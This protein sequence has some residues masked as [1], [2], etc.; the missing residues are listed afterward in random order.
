M[1]KRIHNL[2][3]AIEPGYLETLL[4]S[5]SLPGG[6]VGAEING[7]VEIITIRGAIS[8]R[9]KG[10]LSWLFGETATYESIREHFR[11]ALQDENTAAVIF[12]IDSSGGEVAGLFDLVDEIY[13]ARG[14]KPIYAIANENALSAAYAIASA[15]DKVFLTRTAQV[16]SIGVVAVHVDQSEADKKAGVKFTPIYAGDR[17]VD[18]S[19]HAPL[20]KEAMAIAQDRVNKSY[21][22][23]VS[24]VARNRGI[25]P[26]S[27][28][29]TQAGIFTGED[30]VKAGLAD[31][32]LSFN[33]VV[34][35]ILTGGENMGLKTDLRGLLAGKKPEEIAEAMAAVGFFPQQTGSG[36]PAGQLKEILGLCEV[37][38]VT[39]LAF[40]QGLITEGATVEQAR[41]KILQAK[42][43]ESRKNQIFS[44]VSALST[45]EPDQFV[46]FMK[47]SYGGK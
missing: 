23:F 15:A 13:Q 37:A 24:T 38:G 35:Q 11:A 26:E 1:N 29:N 8:H 12:D 43:D 21:E 4:A 10:F 30:A 14:T 41:T 3:L 27:I 32:I 40:V 6:D 19:Q 25:S 22:L 18:F 17:K 34:D 31:Q 5:P 46:D 44:T 20:S 36:D 9:S 47:K 33:Q 2:S 39:D 28:K 7:D 42:A 45:G 16:G